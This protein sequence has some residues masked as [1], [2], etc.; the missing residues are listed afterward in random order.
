[1]EG[2][3]IL[4][5]E[6]WVTLMDGGRGASLMTPPPTAEERLLSARRSSGGGQTPQQSRTCLENQTVASDYELHGGPEEGGTGSVRGP[7]KDPDAFV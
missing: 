7:D 3:L 5:V 4:H 2:E 1:M 6:N